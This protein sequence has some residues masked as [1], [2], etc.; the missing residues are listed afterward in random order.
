ML[1]YYITSRHA[2]GGSGALLRFVE[3]AL[4]QG[5]DFIQVREKDLSARDLLQ[6]TRAILALPNPA[7]TRILV[8]SR[9][10][11]A[12]A[13]G[14]HGV[15]LPGDSIAPCVLRAIVPPA[16]RIAVS[17]H[18]VE[19]VVRAER[20]GADFAV[21]SPVFEP[22]SKAAW[23]PPQGLERL[24]A[25]CQVRMPVLALGGI[26]EENAA[27]CMEAGAAGIAGISMFQR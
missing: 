20:E 24:R 17:A 10:D 22:I 19:E 12:L 9:A 16:F 4:G 23:G 6:L 11:V 13:A 25:A 26:T 8:N 3:R 7:G 21:F 1:R 14:A 18:S 2:A 5:V 15:H 27:N